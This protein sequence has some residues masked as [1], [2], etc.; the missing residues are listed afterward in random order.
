M[1]I[2][3]F[4]F[5]RNTSKLYYPVRESILS[6]LDFV[7]EFVVAL[8]KGDPGDDT[9]ELLASLGSSK[10]RI[11][12]TAWDLNAYPGG[13]EYAHQTDLAMQA[14]TGDWLFYLQG[15]EVV[16]E[17][18][19]PEIRGACEKY[20]DDPEVEGLL[21][22][23]LH[24]FGDYEHFFSDHCWYKKE[25]RMVKNKQDIHSWRDAQSFRVMPD[26]EGN[27]FQQKGTTRLRCVALEA[28]IFHYGWVRPPGLMQKKSDAAAVSYS[29]KVS[30]EEAPEFDYGRLDRCRVFT[31]SHPAVMKEKISTLNWKDKLR[32][33]GP[34]AIGRK[35]MKHE[36]LKY[37][38]LIWLEENLL[39]GYV[40]GGFK[41]YILLS[42]SQ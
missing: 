40:I 16:H 37:R 24:F 15:D 10:I 38:V 32:F 17:D 8:G 31:G 42:R 41:N 2:S 25:I 36:R 27:Y 23:Y 4:T 39:G 13:S 6:V 3:G 1:K 19:L 29:G 20:L 5:L 26:F 11:I 14:C 34:D 35:R 21:F 30:S 18:D 22:N 12:H 33:S 9:E 7:D 28:R